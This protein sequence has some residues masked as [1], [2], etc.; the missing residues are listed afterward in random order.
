MLPNLEV[1]DLKAV[2][3]NLI[4]GNLDITDA[5]YMVLSDEDIQERIKRLGQSKENDANAVNRQELAD[6]V[7]RVF[8]ESRANPTA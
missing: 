5:I 1:S 6:F 3:M 4:H 2:S 7:Q 8:G